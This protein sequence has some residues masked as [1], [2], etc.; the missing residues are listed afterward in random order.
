MSDLVY[1]P[2]FRD[3]ASSLLLSQYRESP[4]VQALIKALAGATQEIEDISFDLLVSTTITAASGWALDQWGAVVGE[5]RGGLDDEDYRR[6]IEARILANL[7][8]DSTDRMISVFEIVAGP[9]EVRHFELYPA[10]YALTIK[11]DSPLTG[12]LRSRIRT[13]MQS[14]KPAGVGLTLIEGSRQAYQYDL[15]PGLDDG[16]FSRIL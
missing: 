1:I 9:G 4:R 6:F 12:A 2:D 11:R 14:I 8:D 7:S 10:G 13:L 5:D 15:G 3:M 16:E